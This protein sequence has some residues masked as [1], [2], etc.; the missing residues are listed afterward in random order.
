MDIP[1]E[2]FAD[3]PGGRVRY[4]VAGAEEGGTPLLVLHGGPGCTSDYLE[5]LAVFEGASHEHHHHLEATDAYL[6][7]VREFLERAENGPQAP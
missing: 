6:A 5:P 7:V 3:V 2:G 1:Q 4:H